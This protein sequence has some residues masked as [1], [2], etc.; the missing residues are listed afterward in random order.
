MDQQRKKLHEVIEN[1]AKNRDNGS[2]WD[3]NNQKHL[4]TDIAPPK[5]AFILN[6]K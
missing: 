1:A 5:S 6:K 2:K 3:L 4:K